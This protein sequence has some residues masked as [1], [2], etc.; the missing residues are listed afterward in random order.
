MSQGKPAFN[1]E[2]SLFLPSSEFY[3][4]PQSEKLFCIKSSHSKKLAECVIRKS[5][6]LHNIP[7]KY[8]IDI[9]ST[10]STTTKIKPKEFLLE[11]SRRS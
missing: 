9:D 11:K 10:S 2:K 3:D 5:N 8:I 1:L 7:F 4:H 6:L